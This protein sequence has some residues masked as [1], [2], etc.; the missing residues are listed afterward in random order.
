MKCFPPTPPPDPPPILVANSAA[1]QASL[2]SGSRAGLLQHIW[3]LC[4][5]FPLGG[6]VQGCLSMR[7]TGSSCRDSPS[8]ALLGA[9]TPALSSCY[10]PDSP[11]PLLGSLF[12]C[13]TGT[14]R[15]PLLSTYCVQI[16]VLGLRSISPCFWCLG[17]SQ[18]MPPNTVGA[19]GPS[20]EMGQWGHG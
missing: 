19:S 3:V 13:T 1:L 10:N 2:L 12:T 9:G 4:V 18:E 6:H 15:K 5:F 7:I 8:S 14:K 11:C 16:R 17:A 20:R